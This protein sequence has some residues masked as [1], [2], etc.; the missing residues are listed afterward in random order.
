M[1]AVSPDQTRLVSSADGRL[2]FGI[3]SPP[4]AR[5]AVRGAAGV[6]SDGGFRDADIGALDMPGYFAKLSAPPI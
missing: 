6:V 1:T 4:L 3:V 5:L 2:S